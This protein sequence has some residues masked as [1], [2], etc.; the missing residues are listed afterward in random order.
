M[1]KKVV[2]FMLRFLH[3]S[4]VKKV[5]KF[6]LQLVHLAC[7]LGVKSFMLPMSSLLTKLCLSI[8]E[9]WKINDL[10]KAQKYQELL[11]KASHIFKKY[12]N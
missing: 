11:T 5:V 2:K 6:L 12:G 7:A 9:A 4:N 8:P 10:E 3:F 1:S